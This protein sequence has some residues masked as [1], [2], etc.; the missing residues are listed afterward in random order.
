MRTIYFLLLLVITTPLNINAQL[1][2]PL[3][4]N[5]SWIYENYLGERRKETITDTAFIIDSI[6]YCKVWIQRHGNMTGYYEYVRLN[7]DSFYV[8]RN[9]PNPGFVYEEPYYKKNAQLGE[10]WGHPID[11]I[12]S[13]TVIVIFPSSVFGVSVNM[14]VLK[15]IGAGGLTEMDR[16]WTEE[17]GRH[18][19]INFWGEAIEVLK[20]CVIDDV[21]YGDTVFYQPVSVNEVKTFSTFTLFQN[22]PNPFNSSTVI[23]YSIPSTGFVILTLYNNLGEEVKELVREEQ[24]AGVYEYQFT[25]EDLPSGIYYAVLSSR[26]FKQAI[27]IILLK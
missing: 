16:W 9:E 14:K 7:E 1:V 27:K 12:A 11:S 10:T 21:A 23:K 3:N 17:F 4:L 2:A 5:N 15:Y 25:S 6:K 19:S 13:V 22:Y 18:N 8:W 26:E 20:G 24:I